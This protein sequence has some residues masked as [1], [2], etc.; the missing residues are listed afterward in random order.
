MQGLFNLNNLHDPATTATATPS[1][2]L[3]Q[4]IDIFKRLLTIVGVRPNFNQVILD[5]IDADTNDI[6]FPDGAEDQSYQQKDP[7]YLA[8][9]T[10]LSSVSELLLMEGM[11]YEDYEKLRPFVTVLP[12]PTKINI[13]TAP[14]EV[15]AALYPDLDLS[16]ATTFIEDREA[17]IDST[18]DFL[19]ETQAYVSDKATYRSQVDPLIG[20]KSDYFQVK[21]S[22]QIDKVNR[23]LHSK[24][25]RSSDGKLELISRSP[26]VD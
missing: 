12:Q 7:P 15:I 19:D 21:S 8:A 5:W 11:S 23:I 4:Q 26:G 13:N 18:N 24:L 20:V 2:A 25:F 6:R 16:E 14:A 17:A 9:N 10:L 22:V 1:P 3:L